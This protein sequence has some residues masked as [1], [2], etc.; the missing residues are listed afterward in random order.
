M[1]YKC[2]K[3]LGKGSFG[4]VLKARDHKNNVDVAVKILRNEKRFHRQAQDA[5]N[6]ANIVHMLD[7]FT[8]RNHICIS[9]ELLS[10]NLFEVSGE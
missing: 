5:D 9:F 2:G 6:K 8:F 1:F 4:E 7:N 10:L 3:A